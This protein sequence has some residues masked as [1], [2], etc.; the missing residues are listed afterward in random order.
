M[1]NAAVSLLAGTCNRRSGMQNTG[2]DQRPG[3]SNRVSMEAV[4]ATD[5]TELV[6]NNTGATRQTRALAS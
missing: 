6:K 1:L 3:R 4:A 5:E 2:I